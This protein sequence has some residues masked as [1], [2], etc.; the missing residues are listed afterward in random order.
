META[1][2]AAQYAIS[3]NVSVLLSQAKGN[4]AEKQAY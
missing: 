2:Y 3:E 1:K 4:E